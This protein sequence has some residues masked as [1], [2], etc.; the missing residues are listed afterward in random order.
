MNLTR[1][2]ALCAVAGPEAEAVIS[3]SLDLATES[4]CELRTLAYLLHP[5]ML[6]DMG[7]ASAIS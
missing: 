2:K 1:L 4:A 6:D 7:L 3:D 5:P